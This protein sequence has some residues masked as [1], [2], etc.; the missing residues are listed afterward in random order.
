MD[1][2]RNIAISFA[3]EQILAY[4]SRHIF[5]CTIACPLWQPNECGEL[6]HVGNDVI[7]SKLIQRMGSAHDRG[8]HHLR[9]HVAAPYGGIAEEEALQIGNAVAVDWG[10]PIFITNL[11]ELK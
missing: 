8:P 7:Y 9:T 11:H 2:W 1:I 10:L 3:I 4:Q 6:R 5:S